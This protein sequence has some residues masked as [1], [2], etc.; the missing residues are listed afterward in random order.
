M[1]AAVALREVFG[2]V[3]PQALAL[4]PLGPNELIYKPG[5]PEFVRLASDT[6]GNEGTPEDG[7]EA[8]LTSLTGPIGNDGDSL[9]SGDVDLHEAGFTAGTEQAEALA[10]LQAEHAQFIADGQ[11]K[12]DQLLVHLGFQPIGPDGI[13]PVGTGGG[14]GGDGG[15]GVDDVELCYSEATGATFKPD[16]RFGC[17]EPT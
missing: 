13:T 10:P 7:F 9:T 1:Q 6:L 5:D 15:D 4:A 8:I 14:S 17:G 16:I 3:P 12:V 2:P 11:P